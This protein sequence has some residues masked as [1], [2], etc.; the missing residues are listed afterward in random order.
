MKLI[1]ACAITL[2]GLL[3]S[4]LLHAAGGHHAVDDAAILDPGRCHVETW[5]ERGRGG[6]WLANVGP[7]CH[8]GGLEWSLALTRADDGD[9]RLNAWAPQVKWAMETGIEG[10]SIGFSAAT[11]RGTGGNEARVHT[12]NLPLSLAIADAATVHANLGREWTR[13][14]PDAWTW[15]LA[16][17]AGLG[18]RVDAVIEGFGAE[19][20]ES[21]A[22]LGLRWHV[23]PEAV[24]LDLSHAAELGG[25]RDRWWTLGLTWEFDGF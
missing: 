18:E 22:R 20:G 23:V 21:T 24:S 13:G 3:A 15:G 7:A 8:I 11:E 12:L 6:R 16:L 1:N 14:E 10:L 19:R 2:G 4:G 25:A 5:Y 17:E 9:G